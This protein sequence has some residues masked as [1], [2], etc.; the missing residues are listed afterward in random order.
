V[1]IGV[2]TFGTTVLGSNG[3]TVAAGLGT[4]GTTRVRAFTIFTPCTDAINGTSAVV[5][6]SS[7]VSRACNTTVL[8]LNGDNEITSLETNVTSDRAI[9][10]GGEFTFTVDRARDQI[11]VSGGFVSISKFAIFTT[12]FWEDG[13]GESL[14]L[15]TSTAHII[16]GT[17]VVLT[18]RTFTIDRARS[19]IT[20][21]S[22]DLT[23]SVVAFQTSVSGGSGHR[24]SL[25]D[26]S[27]SAS[28]I[29]LSESTPFTFTVFG[30]EVGVAS[31][32]L[33]LTVSGAVSVQTRS[34]TVD[35]FDRDVESLG[36]FTTT[37]SLR[38][39]VEVTPRTNAVDRA[40]VS[41]A[42]FVF[43]F[44]ISVRTSITLVVGSNRNVVG[45]G[46]F[47]TATGH[48]A[49]VIARP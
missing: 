12:I 24:E 5:T 9:S 22:V 26:L 14:S 25:E 47:T 38:A 2:R 43:S 8:G 35:V 37:A 27:I 42:C 33:G 29:T 21:L 4:I 46:V 16:V 45:F 19:S 11:T 15:I 31:L 17:F 10:P 1:T 18:E 6:F 34:S 20:S 40:S 30:T 13:Y 3:N 7:F 49:S 28:D 23:V 48:G 36:L 41:T 39:L 44:T 32:G